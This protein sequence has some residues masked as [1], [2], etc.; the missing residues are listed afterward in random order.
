MKSGL[1]EQAVYFT[2]WKILL[3][4][5][6]IDSGKADKNVRK[7]YDTIERTQDLISHS[8]SKKRGRVQRISGLLATE[9][10]NVPIAA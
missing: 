5:M 7:Q 1:H 8:P 3:S 6:K 4:I 2:C 10:C 9:K